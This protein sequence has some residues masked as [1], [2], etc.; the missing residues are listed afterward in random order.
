MNLIDFSKMAVSSKEEIR[1][2]VGFPHEL[3]VKKS[4]S[5]ID[6]MCKKFISASPIVFISTCNS[7]GKCDVSPRGDLSGCVKI[8]NEKQLV[9][10]DRLGNKKQDSNLN[11]LSNPNIG[12]LFIVP[13][14]EEVL[15]VNGK[16]TVI[17]DKEF[18]LK[19]ELQ[20]RVPLLG[21]GVDVEEVFIHCSRAIRESGIWNLE[22][23][24]SKDQVPTALEI[25]HDHLKLNGVD[26]SK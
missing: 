21:I 20:G 18:L 1:E 23:W 15:R 25:F 22:S 5:I 11:I 7:E 13:G 2:I 17:K 6:E 16:A 12:L 10:P 4:I 26:V 9:I 24:S 3:I 19:M 8:L 14:V